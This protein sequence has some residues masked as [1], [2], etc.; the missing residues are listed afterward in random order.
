LW[1]PASRL[2]LALKS[3]I[4]CTSPPMFGMFE[5]ADKAGGFGAGATLC[6]AYNGNCL[7]DAIPEILDKN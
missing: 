4:F 2:V 7:A 1:D 6:L 5:V 3:F